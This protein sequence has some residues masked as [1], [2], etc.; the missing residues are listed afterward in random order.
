MAR[1]N[2]QQAHNGPDSANA[3]ECG[4][5]EITRCEGKHDVHTGNDEKEDDED[6]R[7][8]NEQNE[9]GRGPVEVMQPFG[10]GGQGDPNLRNDGGER[11][12][13]AKQF[14]QRRPL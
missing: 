10:A 5:V 3:S 8:E 13:V 9:P 14:R 12:K 2:H 7:P 1:I 4:G 11:Y 6:N